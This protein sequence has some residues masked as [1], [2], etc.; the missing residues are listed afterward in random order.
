[1]KVDYMIL[2]KYDITAYNIIS[3]RCEIFYKLKQDIEIIY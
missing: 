2:K 3:L 1:M